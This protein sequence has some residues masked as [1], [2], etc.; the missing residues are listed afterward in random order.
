M[1]LTGKHALWLCGPGSASINGLRNEV[2]EG[3]L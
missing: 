1:E 3:Q 2:A